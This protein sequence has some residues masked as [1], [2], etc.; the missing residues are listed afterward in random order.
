MLFFRGGMKNITT[1]SILG[2]ALLSGSAF[3]GE[4]AAA[5]APAPVA[6]Q[7][8]SSLGVAYDSQYIY[9]GLNVGDDL[10]SAK[11]QTSYV[12]PFTGLDITAGAW[13]GSVKENAVNGQKADELR[14]FVSAAKD[15]GFVK[16]HVGY[17]GYHYF[18]DIS[19]DHELFAGV[20]K[21]IYGFNTSL[22]YFW[23]IDGDFRGNNEGYTEAAISRTFNVAGF[24]LN[25]SA[26]LGYLI[27]EGALSHV[28]TKVSYDYKLTETATLSPYIAYTVELD[29][30]ERSVGSLNLSQENELFAGAALT[31]TF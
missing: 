31:V 20:S 2:G 12:C 24:D 8:Q 16:A 17:I 1:L 13:Y 25:T 14:L 19:D 28:T 23:G 26:T 11:L 9:R 22:T 18:D 29:D 15:L 5:P 3:A 30:L 27:E 6:S 10:V 4:V 7:F 21:E